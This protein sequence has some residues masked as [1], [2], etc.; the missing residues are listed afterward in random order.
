[1][2]QNP[3]PRNQ[4][5]ITQNAPGWIS[6]S[7]GAALGLCL[8]ATFNLCEVFACNTSAVTN[9]LCNFRM[10]TQ[11]MSIAVL[12]MLA[13]ALLMYSMKPAL[14]GSVRMATIALVT[15]VAVFDGWELWEVSQRVP[16]NL[17]QSAMSRPL[18]ILM[19]LAVAGM[20]ILVGDSPSAYG[21]ASL[22]TIAASCTL[23][24][25]GFAVITLQSGA[26]AD[27]IP[28]ENA[29]VLLVIGCQVDSDGNPTEALTDRVATASRI[30][31][32]GHARI[33]VL[34]G[35]PGE[36]TVNETTAMKK[37]ALEA[38]AAETQIVL[39]P[40]SSDV[41]QSILFAAGLPE[42]QEDRRIIVVSHWYQLARIRLLARQA[43]LQVIAVPAEQQHALFGQNTLFAG[44]LA[45]FLV[46][47]CEPAKQLVMGTP[48][49]HA[50]ESISED[51]FP[52]VPVFDDS[53]T[54]PQAE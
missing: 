36:S 33:L 45:M 14:P 28:K 24:I 34:S 54:A 13:T 11:S 23:S 25:L 1:M 53:I 46:A 4:R 50:A 38:G 42:L 8:I 35:G 7:R 9:W 12:A 6:V 26:M 3:A 5:F 16:E 29:P 52:D 47:C 49:P 22:L 18:G 19:L 10:M 43:G 51:A 20:G 39:D 15:L 2:K 17:R 41:P 37:L 31:N 21:R 44:E 48:I 32:D 40:A 30:F 27:A